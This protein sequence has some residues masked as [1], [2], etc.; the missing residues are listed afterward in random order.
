MLFCKNNLVNSIFSYH[1]EIRH[2]QKFD[3]SYNNKKKRLNASLWDNFLSNL[4][5]QASP[6]RDTK[7]HTHTPFK[8]I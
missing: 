5:F 7:T 3:K 8:L 1:Y 2:C 4:T 6:G